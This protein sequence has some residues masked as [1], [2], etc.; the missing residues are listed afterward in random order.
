MLSVGD[1]YDH[2]CIPL[3]CQETD[4]LYRCVAAWYGCRSNRGCLRWSTSCSK[5]VHRFGMCHVAVF[6]LQVVGKKGGDIVLPLKDPTSDMAVIA[7]KGSDL[8]KQVR[9]GGLSGFAVCCRQPCW[10]NP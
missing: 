8:V 2:P 4:G 5:I 10:G 1:W 9:C 6:S 7:R 3:F